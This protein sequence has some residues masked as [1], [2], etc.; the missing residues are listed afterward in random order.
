M[1]KQ[2]T[3]K[4]TTTAKG[5][6]RYYQKIEGKWRRMKAKLGEMMMM[7][8]EASKISEEPCVSIPP[9][10]APPLPRSTV[11][12][13]KT[14]DFGKF[15]EI[16]GIKKKVF[17][18]GFNYFPLKSVKLGEIDPDGFP[19]FTLGDKVF[20][21]KRIV[22]QTGS[23]NIY[24]YTTGEVDDEN[25]Y[26]LVVKHFK[27]NGDY[28]DEVSVSKNLERNIPGLVKERFFKL[29]YTEP[30]DSKNFWGD[31]T[32]SK[33]EDKDFSRY[34]IM[35]CFD[36]NYYYIT[37]TVRNIGP[38]FGFF[39]MHKKMMEIVKHIVDQLV[40]IE[41]LGWIYTD[42]KS[43]N[44]LY[45][46]DCDET[47]S[48]KGVRIK[49]GDLGGISKLGED[50]AFSFPPLFP[51][52]VGKILAFD[53][54]VD[55]WKE[56]TKKKDATW[57]LGILWA[58]IMFLPTFLFHFTHMDDLGELEE[59]VTQSPDRSKEFFLEEYRQ[60]HIKKLETEVEKC[61]ENLRKES[62]TESIEPF[63]FDVFL[64]IFQG[65]YDSMSALK[66]ALE[67]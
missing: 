22:S 44:V 40:E 23:S 55:G 12:S 1:E 45:K 35:K 33:K 56:N 66:T 25:E 48:E 59:R 38:S 57:V 8:Q 30:K 62:A 37:E 20:T 67:S 65:E 39:E 60:M 52:K 4:C 47:K 54:T 9:V 63:K 58:Q 21:K 17:K 46:T 41:K 42:L 43:N 34:G 18:E 27:Y 24:F 7:K 2:P 15:F 28:E 29:Q 19:T 49:L 6:K 26:T 11:S 51:G 36:N 13:E 64:N 32:F 16:P 50:G 61:K 3:Y 31:R 5:H 10:V 53:D 14:K